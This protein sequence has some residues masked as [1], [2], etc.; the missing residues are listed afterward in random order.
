MFKNINNEPIRIRVFNF[1]I[2]REISQNICIADPR[3]Q[4]TSN[5]PFKVFTTS[6]YFKYIFF[7]NY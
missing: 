7:K 6:V 4:F 1:I 3:N 5:Y 2:K